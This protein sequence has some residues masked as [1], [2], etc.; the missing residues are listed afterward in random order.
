MYQ[1]SL[2]HAAVT[3][4][5]HEGVDQFLLREFASGQQSNLLA[6]AVHMSYGHRMTVD[7]L[8]IMYR[9]AFWRTKNWEGEDTIAMEQV[10]R[11]EL[12]G[13]WERVARGPDARTW[14]SRVASNRGEDEIHEAVHESFHRIAFFGKSAYDRDLEVIA[15][16][17]RTIN[18]LRLP[19]RWG[20][21]KIARGM[22][23]S[24]LLPMNR[25]R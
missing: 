22:L 15:R 21:P 8:L 25:E 12:R 18:A 6:E 11:E 2:G 7:E 9:L 14:S 16:D 20:P 24:I 19:Y 1:A 23:A 17:G 4:G 3:D 5:H 10:V 13:F